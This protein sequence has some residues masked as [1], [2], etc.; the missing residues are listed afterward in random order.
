MIFG[1]MRALLSALILTL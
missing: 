1:S